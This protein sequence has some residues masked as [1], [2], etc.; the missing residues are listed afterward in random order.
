MSL[1]ENLLTPCTSIIGFN[2][3][4][5]AVAKLLY[6]K[7]FSKTYSNLAQLGYSTKKA[8]CAAATHLTC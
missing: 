7:I 3:E 5:I 6:L 2:Q 4:A 1:F 8:A